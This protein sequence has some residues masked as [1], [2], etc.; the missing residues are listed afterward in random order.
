VDYWWALGEDSEDGVYPGGKRRTAR[1]KRQK[2]NLERGR[3]N[4][5]ANKNFLLSTSSTQLSQEIAYLTS[6]QLVHL[7]FMVC[8]PFGQRGFSLLFE[9]CFLGHEFHKSC[10]GGDMLFL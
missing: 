1:A 9:L 5:E 4:I 6:G 2:L 8:L 7:L 3:K 10:L